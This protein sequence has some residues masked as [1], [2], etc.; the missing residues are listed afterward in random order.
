M[1]RVGEFRGVKTDANPGKRELDRMRRIDGIKPL[2][3][4]LSPSDG[5]R[6]KRS[7]VCSPSKVSGSGQFNGV[8]K[9]SFFIRL[10][11]CLPTKFSFPQYGAA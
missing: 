3:P 11:L 8:R 9:I 4:T 1:V 2:T 6:E 7:Y 5:A 10:I